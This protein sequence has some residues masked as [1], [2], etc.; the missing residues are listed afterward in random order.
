MS[1]GSICDV[2]APRPPLLPLFRS[3]N[4]LRLLATLLLDPRRRYTITELANT[5]GIPQP[6][7]SR[8]V[9]NLLGTGVIAK[10]LERGRR[11]FSANAESAIFPEL[12]ALMTK[13]MGPV[14]QLRRALEDVAGIEGAY[15]YGSW[16]QRHAGVPGHEPR[17]IDLLVVGHPDVRTVRDRAD[18]VG[19]T[20]GRD[21]NVTVLSADE[22]A[23]PDSAFLRHLKESPIVPVIVGELEDRD[24]AGER[25]S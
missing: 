24:R 7:V 23:D 5:T 3:E 1:S 13:T 22:W 21:V 2:S 18:A 14:T 11:V 15:V 10:D 12:A 4:Q 9:K 6:S 25:A 20:L 8:E 19:R 16:A 17:D